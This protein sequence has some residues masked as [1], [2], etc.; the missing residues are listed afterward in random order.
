A[1]GGQ[2]VVIKVTSTVS[3]RGSAAG[4]MTY[5]GTREVENENGEKGKVD[6][7]IY[8]QNG[9][10]ITSRDERAVALAEWG[11]D[12]REAYA[13]NALATF[14]ITLSDEVDDAALHDALNAAF[15]SKPFLYSRHPDGKVSVFAV[16]D[17]PAKRIAGALR[18]R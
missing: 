18:A 10:A 17:L 3:S 15:G 6:I 16:T 5:L 2:P 12:F 13:V 8:D 11:A 9:I 1:A 14:S 7:P 4:L